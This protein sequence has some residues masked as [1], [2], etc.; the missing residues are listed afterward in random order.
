LNILNG[1]ESLSGNFDII[2]DGSINLYFNIIPCQSF[3]PI[4]V[5]DVSFHIYNV[6][7]IGKGIEIL[8]T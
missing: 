8:E 6:D 1:V 2:V 7:F 3:E 5:N 4:D